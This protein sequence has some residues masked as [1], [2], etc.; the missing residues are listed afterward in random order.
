M[1]PSKVTVTQAKLPPILE[2][3]LQVISPILKEVSSFE[4]L[5]HYIHIYSNQMETSLITAPGRAVKLCRFPHRRKTL[6]L[7]K[8]L[9][10]RAAGLRHVFAAAKQS[11]GSLCFISPGTGLSNDTTHF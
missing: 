6:F 11:Y 4:H 1:N 2:L 10:N 3:L 8:Q 9:V 7:L 5:L